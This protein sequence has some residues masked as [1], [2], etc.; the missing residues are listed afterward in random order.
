MLDEIIGWRQGLAKFTILS[1][2]NAMS[3]TGPIVG[4]HRENN[5]TTAG[6]GCVPPS[7]L[8]ERG[9]PPLSGEPVVDGDLVTGFQQLG[10]HAAAHAPQADKLDVHVIHHAGFSEAW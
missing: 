1:W 4:E 8:A 6:F 5:R 7:R 9:I 2:P 10:S 3:S